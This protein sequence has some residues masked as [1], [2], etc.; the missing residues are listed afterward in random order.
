[1]RAP[2][3]VR[4]ATSTDGTAG[5]ES[6][7]PI[8]RPPSPSVQALRDPA[9]LTMQ[10]RG[11]LHQRG[12]FGDRHASFGLRDEG[13]KARHHVQA[14]TG[15]GHQRQR[16]SSDKSV[17]QDATAAVVHPESGQ[18]LVHHPVQ[19]G[20]KAPMLDRDQRQEAIHMEAIRHGPAF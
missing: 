20:H 13:G 8:V 15:F 9:Q 7:P 11:R 12:L 18:G 16:Q 6:D 5:R 17:G 2:I 3:D 14:H 10:Q 4:S 1:M 19:S